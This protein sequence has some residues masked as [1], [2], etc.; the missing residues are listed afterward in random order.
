[1]PSFNIV[2]I[3]LGYINNK[4]FFFKKDI[5]EKPYLFA[6]SKGV[7]MGNLGHFLHHLSS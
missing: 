6:K 7:K 5:N 3:F 2:I 4:Y 1:M